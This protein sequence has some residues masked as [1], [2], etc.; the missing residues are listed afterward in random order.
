MNVNIT[1]LTAAAMSLR[2]MDY[3]L[4]EKF[5]SEMD[6]YAQNVVNGMVGAPLETLSKAQGMAV[7]AVTIADILRKAPQNYEKIRTS[8]NG[9]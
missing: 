4:W 9:R 8:N 5:V 1:G 7:Q 6:A 2:Q 3:A